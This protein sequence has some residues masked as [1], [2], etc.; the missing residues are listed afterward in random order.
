MHVPFLRLQEET[1]FYQDIYKGS[2]FVFIVPE[3]Y[4][5][6]GRKCGIVE[7]E[8]INL[9]GTIDY[10]I[11]KDGE[12]R[13]YLKKMKP[14]FFPSMFYTKPGRMEKVKGLKLKGGHVADYRILH[15]RDNGEDQI[16]ASTF[17]VQNVDYAETINTLFVNSGKVNTNIPYDDIYRYLTVTMN[18]NGSGYPIN[19][20]LINLIISEICRDPNDVSKP[21]RLSTAIDKDMY[22]YMPISIK[23]SPKYVSP[24]QSITSEVWDEGLVGSIMADGNGITSPLE[25]IMTN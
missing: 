18:I 21:F 11:F 6:E 20:Q 5:E 23:E 24:Y 2:E 14:F 15:Y 22:S 17:T 16:I 3:I 12:T 4:F 19:Y 9:L 1:V 7:G 25:K 8:F 10:A 13:D